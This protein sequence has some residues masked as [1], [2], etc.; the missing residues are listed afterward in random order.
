MNKSDNIVS[1]LRT[2][3]GENTILYEQV[4]KDGTPTIWLDRNNLIQ[5]LRYL[6]NEIVLPYKMLFDLTAIDE[7]TRTRRNGQPASDFSVI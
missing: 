5:V 7:R 3:F 1:E 6:K 2:E 4:T